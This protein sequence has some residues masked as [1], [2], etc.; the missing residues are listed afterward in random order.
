[1][2]KELASRTTLG[3][4][5]ADDLIAYLTGCTAEEADSLAQAIRTAKTKIDLNR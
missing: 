1:M 3:P 4:E 2:A 5:W